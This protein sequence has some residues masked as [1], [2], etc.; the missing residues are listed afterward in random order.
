MATNQSGASLCTERVIRMRSQQIPPTLVGIQAISLILCLSAFSISVAILFLPRWQ[1]ASINSGKSIQLGLWSV[2]HESI[3]NDTKISTT[4]KVWDLAE[5]VKKT[6]ATPDFIFYSRAFLIFG[7]T[8]GL[9][10]TFLA[11]L[12]TGMVCCNARCIPVVQ[13][14]AAIFCTCACML[15]GATGTAFPI[16][17]TEPKNNT[18]QW[19]IKDTLT[20]ANYFTGVVKPVPFNYGICMFLCWGSMIIYGVGT[21]LYIFS[22]CLVCSEGHKP[23]TMR[24]TSVQTERGGGVNGDQLKGGQTE[25][26]VS[27]LTRE[28]LIQHDSSSQM[29]RHQSSS[30]FS[31]RDEQNNTVYTKP[32][33]A[34]TKAELRKEYN[35]VYPE[36]AEEVKA[37]N[38][39]P[40]NNKLAR[41]ISLQKTFETQDYPSRSQPTLT[42][43]EHTQ[44]QMETLS[45]NYEYEQDCKSSMASVSIM[46]STNQVDDDEL[47]HQ[48]HQEHHDV[49]TLSDDGSPNSVMEQQEQPVPYMDDLNALAKASYRLSPAN[50][51]NF[52]AEVCKVINGQRD[53]QT[54]GMF[55]LSSLDENLELDEE[56]GTT[57]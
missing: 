24:F 21:A 54:I 10:G 3:V 15:I 8:S 56:R 13:S 41:A 49:H 29:L 53:S 45:M 16:L 6:A 1:V 57:V 46:A 25:T 51:D 44:Q 36:Y 18:E 26:M 40:N 37:L 17:F 35:P 55:R 14:F 2:C 34:P 47:Q 20:E 52:T 4:C 43:A 48:H 9:I 38:D 32:P 39:S 28:N 33:I 31:Y 5:I 19:Q 42:V 50:S 11:I 30:Q 27:P 7:I 23:R 22:A 12:G